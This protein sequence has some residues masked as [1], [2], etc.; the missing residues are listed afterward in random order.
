MDKDGTA[1]LPW[2]ML[3]TPEELLAVTKAHTFVRQFEKPG[4]YRSMMAGAFVGL[5]INSTFALT[6]HHSRHDFNVFYP[7]GALL[8]FYIVLFSR[9]LVA[10]RRYKRER[11][12]LQVLERDHP[13]ELAWLQEEREEAKVKAHLAALHEIEREIAKAR[14]A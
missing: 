3:L 9:R 7:V 1:L 2:G 12:L 11:L 14:P 5:S 6:L 8:L 13:D 10:N 4:A